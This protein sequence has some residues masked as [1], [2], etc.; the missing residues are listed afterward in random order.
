MERYVYN[1]GKGR[2]QPEEWDKV[3]EQLYHYR[4]DIVK[5]MQKR[6]NFIKRKQDNLSTR[7]QAL[8]IKS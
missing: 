2:I 7:L 3:Q 8:L 5:M 1:G 6:W 4:Y